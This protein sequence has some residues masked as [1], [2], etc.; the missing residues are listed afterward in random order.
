VNWL[1]DDVILIPFQLRRA[2]ILRRFLRSGA[3]I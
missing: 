1:G 3:L 2:S